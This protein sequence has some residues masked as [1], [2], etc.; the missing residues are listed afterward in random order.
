MNQRITAFLREIRL[1]DVFTDAERQ[2][3][4]ERMS[5]E[6]YQM[7]RTVAGIGA[8]QA[9][10]YLVVNGQ[11]RKI[12]ITADGKETNQGLIVSGGHFG[13]QSLLGT[14]AQPVVV[15]ASTELTVLR[16]GR[17]PFRE[18]IGQHPE[19]EKYFREYVS[20]DILRTF[21][22]NNT[23]LTHVD[24]GALRSLLD[25][26][27]M[28]VY[29]PGGYLVREGEDGDAFYILKE[30]TALVEKGEEGNVVNRLYPGDFFGELALLTGEPRQAS[31]RASGARVEAF[32]LAKSDFDE[33]IRRY[34][35]IL[36]SIRRISAHYA[37][38]PVKEAVEE[39]AAT[40]AVTAD[41]EIELPE[42]G[43]TPA[44]RRRFRLPSLR[45]RRYP[46]LLQQNEMDCGPTCLTMLARYYGMNASVNRMRER[47]NVGTEG[48]S[49]L[50]LTETAESLGFETRGLK[51]SMPLLRELHTPFIAHWN[52]NHYVMVYEFD[53]R[54]GAVVVDP[55]IGSAETVSPEAFAK[56]WSGYAIELKPTERLGGLD[57][58][59]PLWSRYLA[60]FRPYAGLAVW[61]VGL[62]VLIELVY[63]VFPVMTQQVF[64][65]VLDSRDMP[66]LSLLLLAML[67]LA[68]FS[69]AGIAVRQ[70]LVGRLANRIDAAM[71]DGFYRHLMR[72]PFSYFARRTTGDIITRVYENEK[73]RRLLTDHG[74][75]LL[76]DGLTMAVYGGLMI[77]YHAGL[78][79]IPLV[80]IP[81][82]AVLY[83]FALP[84]MRRNFRKQLQ[85][86]GD[87]Q[88]AIVEMVGAIA[89]VKGMAVEETVRAKLMRLLQRQLQLRLEGNRLEVIVQA[90]SAGIRQAANIALLYFGAMQVMDGRLSVGTLVAFTVLFTSFMYAVETI[91]AMAGELS[92]AR[93]SMER[94]NDVYEAAVEH[95]ESDRFRVLSGLRGHI[96]FENVSFRY[97]NGGKMILQNLNL[98]IEP[99][100]TIAL[101]GRSGSG[102][103]TLANL[104]LKLLEPTSGTIYVD[105]YPLSGV[106][107]DSIR[108][109]VGTV[110]QETVLFRGTVRENIALN[111]EEASFAELE[112]A[113]KLAGADSFIESLPLGY[114]TM[115][116]EGGVRLSGG[117]RQRIA[118]AR[119]LIRDPR[120]LVFDEATSAL[121]TELE[122]IVQDNME[123]MM[124]NRTTIIIAH[125]LSTIRSADRIVVL[126][127]GAIA[128][129]G[130]HEEL[131]GRKGL[132]HYL[133]QQQGV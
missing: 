70:V 97:Y 119:A 59:E 80:V 28:C 108:Q 26:L 90:G 132:Y 61:T 127:R 74:V 63:L 126:D 79:L 47:C 55:A 77:Y 111:G 39:T 133:V 84:R 85:A 12:G 71:L 54:R 22:K 27:E 42:G 98:E 115:I 86:E 81:V 92:E 36:E 5:M 124:R 62:S 106:H 109:Q 58:R 56:H 9:A 38:A 15:R 13:E 101:V 67:G 114:D 14:E 43:P 131:L 128:E 104:L 125:R 120:I 64:D 103:S 112:R 122:R 82:Y 2:L 68:V 34:P 78:A 20:S 25:R 123:T 33:L 7:G 105:G 31:V 116:G 10:F 8:E 52:G 48:A 110:P 66:L 53:E 16:M 41:A 102:K 65:R 107:A 89:S 88:S 113:A 57:D 3:L 49:M 95:P 1:F 21:L 94:L 117:Q 11:A 51:T 83:G 121:D 24:H 35:V 93:T 72:L 45:F 76:L 30:G 17:E 130:T 29:E 96:R 75:H 50:A 73:I 32:R 87:S 18:M 60:F 19:M 100:Q 44:R 91:S 69:T 118:I 129:S 37:P 40:A 4:A 99:G 23:V 46:A 6:T